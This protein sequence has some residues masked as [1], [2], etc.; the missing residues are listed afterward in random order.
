MGANFLLGPAQLGETG[1]D[2]SCKA[3]GMRWRLLAGREEGVGGRSGLGGR[4]T[5]A[6]SA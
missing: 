2:E 4:A 5:G 1:G 6:N 3:A